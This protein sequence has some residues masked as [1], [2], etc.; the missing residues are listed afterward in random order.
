MRSNVSVALLDLLDAEPAPNIPVVRPSV[1]QRSFVSLNVAVRKM[2]RGLV[3]LA[4]SWLDKEEVVRT[5]KKLIVL[6]K[7]FAAIPAPLGLGNGL[8]SGL[9]AYEC[10]ETV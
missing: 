9:M 4:S 6:D 2:W 7:G 3:S 5:S 8:D 1:R 10:E